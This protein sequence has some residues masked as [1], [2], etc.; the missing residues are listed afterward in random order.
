MKLVSFLFLSSYVCSCGFVT[1]LLDLKFLEITLTNW[2]Y[3]RCFKAIVANL[4]L[5]FTFHFPLK[6]ER[7]SFTKKLFTHQIFCHR[8]VFLLTF[9]TGTSTTG[10]DI[11]NP[12]P[13]LP[14][15]GPSKRSSLING[16]SCAHKNVFF[17]MWSYL[18]PCF[19]ASQESRSCFRHSVKLSYTCFF[20][21]I[22]CYI[23]EK[24]T[25]APKYQ[26]KKINPKVPI[27]LYIAL[28]FLKQDY[29][30]TVLLHCI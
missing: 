11:I 2:N 20:W 15:A 5:S 23:P 22:D 14:C 13:P 3:S 9:Y 25:L 24:I 7:E 19:F 17:N 21:P 28:L 26:V 6:L 12:I 18:L 1:S 10:H 29:S 4:S 16:C 27:I 8:I 30:Q